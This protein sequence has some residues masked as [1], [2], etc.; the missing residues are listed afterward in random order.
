M[1]VDMFFEV[2]DSYSF[3]GMKHLRE[4]IVVVNCWT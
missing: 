4:G 1:H 2:Q 3:N